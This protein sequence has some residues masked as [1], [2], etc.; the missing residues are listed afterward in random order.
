M[1]SGDRR[2][3]T[4]GGK[5]IVLEE[6]RLIL[7]GQ[8]AIAQV[9]PGGGPHSGPFGPD[10]QMPA[11]QGGAGQGQEP[12]PAYPGHIDGHPGWL[13]ASV[14]EKDLSNPTE[15]RPFEVVG[16]CADQPTHVASIDRHEAPSLAS[17]RWTA[18]VPFS[19]LSGFPLHRT[20]MQHF[21][22]AY[23]DAEPR[24]NI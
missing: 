11:L 21:L 3:L 4:I 8:L 14:V 12:H 1:L 2:V 24:V 15:A 10:D 9:D 23:V 7:A 20:R 5:S 18:A 22:S 13:I 17:R 6:T 16:N 19:P